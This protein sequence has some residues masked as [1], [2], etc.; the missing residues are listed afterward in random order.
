MVEE[1]LI[2]VH[3]HLM[4]E[5]FSGDVGEVIRRCE[6]NKMAAVINAGTDLETSSAAIR[7]A[8]SKEWV[9]ALAVFHPH[10]AKKW[11]DSSLGEIERLLD[12]PKVVGIGE[13]GLDYHYDFSPR[14]VQIQV[15][16]HQWNL[17]AKRKIA[18][19]VHVREAF[20]DFFD[21]VIKNPGPSR[22]LMHCFSGNM[23]HARKA[24]DLGFDFSIGGAITFK[25]SE[26]TRNVFRALPITN[27]HLE[28]DCPY[29]APEPFRGKRCEPSHVLHTFRRLCAE[30]QAD[31]PKVLNQ[32]H[33]NA[34]RLFSP[35]LKLPNK[36]G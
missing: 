22:V 29:L 27:I 31:P 16:S 21:Y 25:K 12:H 36:T 24:L 10:D 18:L 20:D 23:D 11:D 33:E 32:L 9:W 2:D 15:F 28:T 34:L 7:L 17:A 13:I 14:D 3:A 26:E 5:K 1:N 19:V 6:E 35:K 8:E 30:R 4:D